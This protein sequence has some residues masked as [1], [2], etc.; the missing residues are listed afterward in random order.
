MNKTEQENFWAG[1]FG[2]EYSRRNSFDFE[3]W[4]AWYLENFGK[5]KEAINHEFLTDLP[6][7]ARILEVGCNVGQQLHCLQRMGFTN[8]YGVEL[9]PSAVEECHRRFPDLNVIV[10]S[11]FDLP[12]KDAFFDLVFTNGVLIHIAPDH[13]PKIMSEVYRCT[14]KYIWGFEYYSETVKEIPYRGNRNVLWKANYRKM[15]LD[16]FSL[17]AEAKVVDYPYIS[18]AHV[19]NVDQMFMLVKDEG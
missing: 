14:G 9:Q 4:N 17:L 3:G 6:R 18:E 1:A 19:G 5:S 15:Y 12:F 7:D 2:T 11:G 8:L 10:G 13:L 16:A